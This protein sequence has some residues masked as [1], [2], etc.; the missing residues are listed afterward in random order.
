MSPQAADVAISALLD[1]L[2]EYD[3]DDPLGYAEA[4]Q[5]LADSASSEEAER[6]RES[7]ASLVA[8]AI[9]EE[10]REAERAYKEAHPRSADELIA[11]VLVEDHFHR[12]MTQ[13]EREI[14]AA[15]PARKRSATE[16]EGAVRREIRERQS[17]VWTRLPGGA[18]QATIGAGIVSHLMNRYPSDKHLQS[19]RDRMRKAAEKSQK[20]RAKVLAEAAR[21][22]K[23]DQT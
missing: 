1:H 15:L 14:W 10:R 3:T 19:V 20:E 12:D 11:A 2:G 4:L 8:S 17:G 18:T 13:S 16:F 21:R 9:E 23:E 7:A 22:L 6:A 5:I